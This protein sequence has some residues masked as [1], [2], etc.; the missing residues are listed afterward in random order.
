ME[1]TWFNKT[2]EE[3]SKELKTNIE[4]GLSKEQV[5]EKQKEYGFNELKAKKKKSFQEFPL[6]SLQHNKL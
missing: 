1:K 3:T 2:V 6:G 4:K 5:E